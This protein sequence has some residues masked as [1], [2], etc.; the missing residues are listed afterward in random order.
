MRACV[1]HGAS[2]LRLEHRPDPS[3]GHGGVTVAVALGGIC[4][5]DLHYF[6]DGAVGSFVV[7]EPLVPGHEIVGRIRALG[8]GVVGPAPGTP[9]AVHPA[10][11]CGACR[12]CREGRPNLCASVRYLGSAA[13]YPHVQGGLAEELVVRADQ[14]R[15]LPDGLELERAVLA[16]PLSVALHALRRAGAIAGRRVLVT[17]AGPIG[18]LAVALARRAGAAE[19]VS[20]DLVDA[21]LERAA[22]LGATVTIRADRTDAGGWPAE[23]DAAFEA[24]GS[25]GG[26]SNCVELVRPGGT[27]VMVGMPPATGL[28]LP[29]GRV[30]TRELTLTG[31]FRIGGELEEALGLLA[32]GLD[33]DGVVSHVFPL[34]EA[35]AAFEIAGDRSV[36]SKVLLQLAK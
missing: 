26:L 31:A 21:A 2:D 35:R 30:V 13:Q 6:H 34:A 11:P 36:A 23:V 8:D 9:V 19:I 1:I 20:S 32:G 18:L 4:G 10:T 29:A 16:E 28:N 27:V 24:S 33:V 22:R 5:S 7:R 3:P 12:E 17:G 15:V 25:Q 14:V